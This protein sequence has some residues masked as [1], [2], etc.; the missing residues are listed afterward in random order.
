MDFHIRQISLPVLPEGRAPIRV[1]HFSDI[2]LTPKQD[3][4]IEF[5][6]SWVDLNPDLVIS[7]GDHITD[8]RSI[9]LLEEALGPILKKPG[10][11]VFGSNDYFRP[12]FK[13]PF[14][15][16]LP[17][18]G[19]RI[20]GEELPI[21]DLE[22]S[23]GRYGWRNAA[24][25]KIE[26]VVN[27][28]S[29]EVRGTDDAHLNR[30]DYSLVSGI[31]GNVDLSLGIT[32]APYS[33]LLTS[34]SEDRV[35]LIFSGHTHGGQIRIPWLGRTR[36]LITNCDLPNWRSRGLTRQP[37]GAWLH[38]SAG[39]GQSPFFPLRLWCPREITIMRLTPYQEPIAR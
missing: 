1:L 7:T 6:R 34:M 12:R 10:F 26:T 4:T 18:R 5:I 28:V 16:L 38:V 8:A 15:Y 35:D 33:R 13:N 11:Y 39:L 21:R 19:K 27:G 37:D 17:D 32:H 22:A 20:H 3:H 24:N 29:L 30:D 36:S 23:L 2:H 14:R 25:A 31:R 9:P